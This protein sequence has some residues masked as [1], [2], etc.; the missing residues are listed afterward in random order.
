MPLA[1]SAIYCYY[2]ACARGGSP[3]AISTSPI[4]PAAQHG[5]FTRCA[6]RHGQRTTANRVGN[7]STNVPASEQ[8][9][10]YNHRQAPAQRDPDD[11]RQRWHA[12]RRQRACECDCAQQGSQRGGE[13]WTTQSQHA[14]CESEPEETKAAGR[15][16][17][18]PEQIRTRPFG[19]LQPASR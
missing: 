4:T 5:F 18:H 2:D 10:S 6:R 1:G 14:Y 12:P 19:Q 16:P 13:I 7:G 8:D 9:P 3:P 11:R 17:L 15:R